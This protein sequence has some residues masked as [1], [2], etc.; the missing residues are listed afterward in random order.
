LIYY[1]N[2]H[3]KRVVELTAQLWLHIPISFETVKAEEL[4]QMISEQ[5]HCAIRAIKNWTKELGY[6]KPRGWKCSKKPTVLQ[7]DG[8]LTITIWK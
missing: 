2:P 8:C 5:R 1:G 6:R 4:K 7:L 3:A